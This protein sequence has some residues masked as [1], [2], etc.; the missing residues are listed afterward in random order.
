MLKNEVGLF[1][2]DVISLLGK[3]RSF[4]TACMVCAVL[5]GIYFIM[6]I[7]QKMFQTQ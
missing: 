3:H 6:S 7:G 2:I 4:K 1:D 5:L